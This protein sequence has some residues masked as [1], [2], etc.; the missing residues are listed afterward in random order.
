MDDAEKLAFL[1]ELHQFRSAHPKPWL[2]AGDFN[3]IY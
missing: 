2:L 1:D 3:M